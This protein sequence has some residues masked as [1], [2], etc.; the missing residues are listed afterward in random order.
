[1][2]LLMAIQH[3]IKYLAS[4]KQYVTNMSRDLPS[5]ETDSLAVIQGTYVIRIQC[6]SSDGMW[7]CMLAHAMN[8]GRVGTVE[9][10]LWLWVPMF[11]D[12]RNHK[13]ATH[14]AKFL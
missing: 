3:G 8:T 13:Y 14:I 9:D 5:R 10:L 6:S 7:Y 4:L 2:T 1:M 12:S 11:Q